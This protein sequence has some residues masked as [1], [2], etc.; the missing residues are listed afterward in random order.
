MHWT[1]E[2]DH[3]SGFVRITTSGLFGAADH[4]RMID[5]ILS[6]PFWRPGTRTLFDHRALDFGSAT[7]EMMR[8]AT[9]NHLANDD[10]IGNGRTAILVGSLAAFGSVRQFELLVADH[11]ATPMRVFQ[12]EAAALAWLHD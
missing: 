10:R 4:L 2:P 12:D 7:Y 11:S 5:D 8:A 3:A 6:Q 9:A 1:I